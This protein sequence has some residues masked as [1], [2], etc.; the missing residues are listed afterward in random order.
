[1]NADAAYQQT[2]DAIYAGYM[3]KRVM[4]AGLFDRDFK[5]ADLI[6]AIARKLDLL[7]DPARTVKITGSKG[8]GTTSRLMAHY[9]QHVAGP[10]AKIALFVSPEEFEHTDRMKINGVEIA[11]A[12]FVE[13]YDALRPSL[14]E[15]EQGLTGS[16]Y[17]S[18]FGIFLL[19]ALAWFKQREI[20]WCVLETG[21]GA[22]HDE[23][24]VLPAGLAVITSIL[25]EHPGHLG[26]T[27]CDIVCEKLAIARASQ[28]TIA[29]AQ[30]LIQIEQCGFPGSYPLVGE[31]PLPARTGIPQ[32]LA[33]DDRLARQA[34]ASLLPI[35]D[36]QLLE[37]D[38]EAVS[39]AWGKFEFGGVDV[40][41]DALISLDSLDRDWFD[42]TFTEAS[43]LILFSLPDDKDRRRLT[44]FVESLSVAS[45]EIV[46]LGKRGYL[47]YEEAEKRPERI[48]ARL[49]YEDRLGFRETLAAQIAS[50][51][52]SRVYCFGTHTFI[53][54]VKSA[55]TKT[56]AQR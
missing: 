16:A 48:C 49:H 5:N 9:L 21:R 55:L 18:P 1:M 32:W 53:R 50:H 26:P 51:R 40:F 47:H 17:L 39:A 11:R 52:P 19:I 27:I 14:L 56:A 43:T 36:A 38:I 33:L 25:Y 12:E 29:S 20:D 31:A 15:V 34:L 8:K 42:R 4:V 46:L 23:V 54:L 44:A 13:H 28:T 22:A 24:G 41:Y 35:E 6:L 30:A 10:Q 45:A 2:L 37:I 7:P 3:R